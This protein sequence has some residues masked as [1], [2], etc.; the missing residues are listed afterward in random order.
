MNKRNQVCALASHCADQ[1]KG[2]LKV[3]ILGMALLVASASVQSGGHPEDE[4]YLS[5]TPGISGEVALVF[6]SEND[7][8]AAGM[9]LAELANDHLKA[10]LLAAESVKNYR[11]A[12]LEEAQREHDRSTALYEEGSLSKVE[13]AHSHIA[14]LKAKSEYDR[15]L[16]KHAFR[17]HQLNQSR[18]VTPVAGKVVEVGIKVGERIVVEHDRHARIL[19]KASQ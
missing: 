15:A 11:Q 17:L 19:I 13:L 4:P 2:R 12:E 7:E 9:V 14:Y 16:A 3:A 1:L 10:A 5:L 6:V 8:V 18:I